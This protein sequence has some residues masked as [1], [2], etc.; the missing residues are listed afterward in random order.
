MN[1]SS[2]MNR[3]SRFIA[4]RSNGN[5][6]RTRSLNLSPSHTSHISRTRSLNRMPLIQSKK[7]IKSLYSLKH[8]FKSIGPIL[9][10]GALPTDFGKMPFNESE[11]EAHKISHSIRSSN[12]IYFLNKDEIN[13][14]NNFP[15]VVKISN[16]ERNKYFQ[17]NLTQRDDFTKIH[18]DNFFK[19]I[20]FDVGVWHH[21]FDEGTP[22]M[23]LITN[24]LKKGGKI[25]LM[26]TPKYKVD[27]FGSRIGIN[28]DKTNEYNKD[29][30]S[31]FEK[32]GLSVE[33][34]VISKE[35]EQIFKSRDL[36]N[37]KFIV[38]EK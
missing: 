10:L 17:I 25:Y 37:I 1:K 28:D 18:K 23:D 27:R 22:Q 5:R 35:I 13:S 3:A 34:D 30:M 11:S 24:L 7:S 38:G 9:I 31:L 26:Q 36:D 21:L 32:A 29:I 2:K 14:R 20:I 19:T 4:N 16:A 15:Y 8:Y 6:K 33:K 12:N